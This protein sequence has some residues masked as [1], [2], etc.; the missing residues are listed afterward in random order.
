MRRGATITPWYGKVGFSPDGG[1]TALLPGIIG[2]KQTACW[3]YG[4]LTETAERC[5]DMGLVH[6]VTDADPVDAALAWAQQVSTLERDSIRQ[7]RRLLN[8]ESGSL[9][10]RLEAERKLFVEQIQTPQARAGIARFLGH[11]QE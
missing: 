5:L 8:G 4:N 6:D 1:W 9:R 11:D 7:T 10:E 2:R 3:L